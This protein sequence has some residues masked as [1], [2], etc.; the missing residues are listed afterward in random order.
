MLRTLPALAYAGLPFLVWT[1]PTMA[2]WMVRWLPSP[3]L[4]NDLIALRAQ[5]SQARRRSLAPMIQADWAA[6][7]ERLGEAEGRESL[8]YRKCRALLVPSHS[9]QQKG[10]ARLA[11]T[12]PSVLEWTGNLGFFARN[13]L[14]ALSYREA[15]VCAHYLDLPCP[16]LLPRTR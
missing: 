16:A 10:V 15:R 14:P 13:S 5:G 7:V 3:F 9:Q 11:P 8:A 12:I 6:R 4:T 2:R 1:V